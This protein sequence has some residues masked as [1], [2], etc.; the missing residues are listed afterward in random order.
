METQLFENFSR[1]T[2]RVGNGKEKRYPMMISGLFH[3]AVIILIA[4]LI[5]SN[6]LTDISQPV[7]VFS[8]ITYF[9]YSKPPAPP[10]SSEKKSEIKKILE[11][12]SSV[13]PVEVLNEI[14]PE[15]PKDEIMP[16]ED[17]GDR[18]GVNGGV[19]GGVPG[20]GPGVI[21][22]EVVEQPHPLQSPQEPVVI[23]SNISLPKRIKYVHPVYPPDA[24]KARVEGTVVV[25]AVIGKDGKIKSAIIIKPLPLLSLAALEAVKKWEFTPMIVGGE[26]KEFTLTV[27][28]N[29]KL[30]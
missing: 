16:S 21:P 4:F 17:L 6:L 23:K 29:F 15:P 27:T 25:E 22:G 19:P 30:T 1:P 5:N 11:H 9:E 7:V 8:S 2:L 13:P 3:L 12:D 18:D 20:G 24:I 26:T 14:K 28:I 10:L